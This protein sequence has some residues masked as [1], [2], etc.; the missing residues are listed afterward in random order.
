[1]SYIALYRKFRPKTFEEVKGQEQVTTILKNQI[2]GNRIGHAYIFSGTRGT[3]KTSVAKIFAK[4]VNCENPVEGSPC[5]VCTTC[6]RIEEGLN[7]NVVEVDAASSNGVD[8]VR[9]IIEEVRYSPT[10]GKYKVYIID[11]VHM[12]SIGAFNALLKTLE[13][14]PSYAI[15]ILATTEKYKIPTTI[16]S[17]CQKYDFR[18]ITTE[19]IAN[20]LR[21]LM[22]EEGMEYEEE[23]I[24]FVARK[25]DGSMRDALSLLDQC[26]SFY[27]GEKLSYEHSLEVLGAVDVDIYL[28]LFRELGELKVEGCLDLVEE[29]S[30]AGM[31]IEQFVSDFVWFLRNL[32]LLKVS[33][34]VESRM[35]V[36]R[37]KIV[38]MKEAV[39]GV[40]EDEIVRMLRLMSKLSN[41]IKYS[42]RKRTELEIAF[43]KLCKPEMEGNTE[44]LLARI[45]K[46]ETLLEKGIL[47]MRKEEMPKEKEKTP[48]KEEKKVRKALPEEAK[49]IAKEFHSIIT[50]GNIKQPL[51]AGL[52]KVTP[53]YEEETKSLILM[54]EEEILKD[55]LE[56]EESLNL[57]KENIEKVTGVDCG[58]KI[59]LEKDRRKG[60]EMEILGLE[61]IVEG[62]VVYED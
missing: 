27:F 25:G 42:L 52:K 18:R 48:I 3:G 34:Q 14:P 12:L 4:A 54:V 40:G 33:K 15:F 10:E 32:L 23:A 28:R 45:R 8:N 1:M 9:E 38:L 31:D 5:G 47:P 51:R 20:R 21:E 44:A 46:L 58:L 17:R 62:L 57:I 50:M 29:I 26:I 19:T 11:E 41:E 24:E 6:K 39:E 56:K 61:N 37:D 36:S 53:F 7:L 60:G 2:K 16:H 43:I 55:L 30:I 49:K 13:E 35:D 22:K 59:G